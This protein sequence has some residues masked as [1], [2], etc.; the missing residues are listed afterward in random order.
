M[1]N[2]KNC[3]D[4]YQVWVDVFTKDQKMVLSGTKQECEDFISKNNANYGDCDY[5]SV[6]MV[7]PHTGFEE[8]FVKIKC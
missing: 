4:G 5:A 2:F 3:T 6:F 7:A 1:M 8:G